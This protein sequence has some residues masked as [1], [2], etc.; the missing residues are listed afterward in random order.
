LFQNAGPAPS[1]LGQMPPN[2]GLPG[3]PMPPGFFPVSTDTHT[4][5][6]KQIQRHLVTRAVN[7]WAFRSLIDAEYCKGLLSAVHFDLEFVGD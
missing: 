5:Y 1:P 4:A 3:G 2:D 7:S 6:G